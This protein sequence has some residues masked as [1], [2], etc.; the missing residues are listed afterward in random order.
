[1]D[2]A[3]HVIDEQ[4]TTIKNLELSQKTEKDQFNQKILDLKKEESKERMILEKKV[5]NDKITLEDEKKK[6]K[7]EGTKE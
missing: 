1:V 7:A 5:E 4:K 3:N 2:E 6:S